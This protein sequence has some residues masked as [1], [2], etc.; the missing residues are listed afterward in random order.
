MH[1]DLNKDFK[2]AINLINN[3]SENV[4]ITGKAGTGKSTLLA[5]LQKHTKKNQ[6]VLAP[7]GVAALNVGGQTIHRFFGF[8]IDVTIEKIINRSI[9]PKEP[10]LYKTIDLIIIDEISMLRA[11]LL[12]CID[13]FLRIYGPKSSKKPNSKNSQPFGGIQMIFV[14]DL[15]Q[16]PP[17]VTK[18][19]KEIFEKHYATPY[20]FSAK[21]MEHEKFSTLELNKVYRQ[22]DNEFVDLLNKIR[23]KTIENSDLEKLNQRYIASKNFKPLNNASNFFTISLT[24]TNKQSDQINENKLKELEGKLY[25][26][27]AKIDGEFSKEY[28][29]TATNLEFKIN[30]QIMMLNNDPEHRWVN[31]SIGV[32]KDIEINDYK[33]P[34]VKILLQGRKEPITVS[35]TKWEVLKFCV[36][37]DRLISKP[38]GSFFQLPFRLAWAVTIHKSQGKTFDRVIIDIGRGTF[39]SGQI[40]VALSR[41]SSFQG[42]ELKVPIKLGD[43]K[44][45]PRILDFLTSHAYKKTDKA[46]TKQDKIY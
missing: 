39:V 25:S 11:D 41:C 45:D 6:V 21:A 16:L 28:Y 27:K 20:F 14:G 38:A 29:P 8:Y 26:N 17:V 30:C 43:I 1:P 42:I 36:E 5:Y 33:K 13:A 32:I 34:I 3:T 2:E 24:T 10:K 15:Y 19:Q 37:D 18:N 12:D 44:T 4:F 7:T 31:G 40:Y 35:I 22:K 46:L 23:N 9:R